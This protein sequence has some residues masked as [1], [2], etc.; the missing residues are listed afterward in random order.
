VLQPVNADG[1]SVFKAGGTVP[2]K[3]ALTDASAGITAL[4]ATLAVAKISNSIVGSDLE[5]VSSSPASTGNTF[6]YDPT[7][8]QYHH[9]WGTK[10]LTAGSYQLRIDLGDGVS[11]TVTVSLK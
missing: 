11:H 5:P 10:G 3:F 4:V 7:G 2:V 1:S 8:G 9:H 6:R